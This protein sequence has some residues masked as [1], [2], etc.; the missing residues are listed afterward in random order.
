MP[1]QLVTFTQRQA[2]SGQSLIEI[3]SVCM[4]TG[5]RKY[6]DNNGCI[7]CISLAG[8]VGTSEPAERAVIR[9]DNGVLPNSLCQQSLLV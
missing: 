7:L 8:N 5:L 3:L 1:A 6:P 2:T 4:G 9:S